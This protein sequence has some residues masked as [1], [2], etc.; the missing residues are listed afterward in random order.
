MTYSMIRGRLIALWDDNSGATLTEFIILLPFFIAAFA[1][2]MSMALIGQQS[3]VV[4][5]EASKA[6]WADAYALSAGN[7][8]TEMTPRGA[9]A[10]LDP[11]G[12]DGLTG[13]VTDINAGLGGHWAEAWLGAEAQRVVTANQVG[14][15][16]GPVTNMG[17]ENYK[18]AERLQNNQEFWTAMPAKIYGSGGTRAVGPERAVNDAITPELMNFEG[19]LLDNIVSAVLSV[20]GAV[21]GQMAGIRYGEGEG[22]AEQ[23]VRIIGGREVGFTARYTTALS[24]NPDYWGTDERANWGFYYLSNNFRTSKNYRVLLNM[25]S[26][27]LDRNEAINVQLYTD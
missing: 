20:T 4:K 2:L 25:L 16:T 24:P 21:P 19:G 12:P 1:G 11:S 3:V 23:S 27:Q 13:L 8:M 6:M 14:Y 17:G 22:T 26:V 15:Q 5:A 9:F 18:A 10:R 7:G